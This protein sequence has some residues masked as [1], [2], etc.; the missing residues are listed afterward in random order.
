MGHHSEHRV[1]EHPSHGRPWSDGLHTE[2]HTCVELWG[3]GW[4]NSATFISIIS[5]YSKKCFTHQIKLQFFTSIVDFTTTLMSVLQTLMDIVYNIGFCT[6]KYHI[7]R[8]HHYEHWQNFLW[9]GDYDFGSICLSVSNFAKKTLWTDYDEIYGGG[10]VV[11]GVST[12]KSILV[13]I[14]ITMLTD[15][16]EI[17]PS[18]NKSWADFDETF[19]IALQYKEQLMNFLGCSGS[20]CWLSISKIQTMNCIVRELH[21]LLLNM[22]FAFN[23]C[24]YTMFILLNL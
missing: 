13:A 5:A 3:S 9:Q 20:P 19:R 6:V 1:W 4:K 24:S 14:R 8:H 23:L 17:R 10:R 11:K 15:Q 16:S 18:L 7:R 21:S 22:R 2:L 12:S